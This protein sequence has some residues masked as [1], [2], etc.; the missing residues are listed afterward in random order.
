VVAVLI[1][2]STVLT[3]QHYVLDIPGGVVLAGF[4]F[5]MFQLMY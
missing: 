4:V 1:S 5:W 2:A 3:K